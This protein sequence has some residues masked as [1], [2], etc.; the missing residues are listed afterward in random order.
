VDVLARRADLLD[1]AVEEISALTT[2]VVHTP[3]PATRPPPGYI[4]TDRLRYL[5]ST[6][7]VDGGLTRGLL[8]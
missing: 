6:L 5:Y 2:A 4:D 3:W 1:E 7:L 8:S